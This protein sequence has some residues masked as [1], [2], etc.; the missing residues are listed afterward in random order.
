MDNLKEQIKGVINDLYGVDDVTVD[1]AS[2]PSEIE[3]DYSTNVAMRLARQAGKAPRQIAEEIIEKL[4]NSGF[5]FSIAGPGFIN[6]VVS[7]KSLQRQLD[8]VWSDDYGNNDSGKGRLAISEFPSTNIAKP[9]SV[10]HLRPGTQGWAAKKVLEANGWKVLTDNHLGDVGTPFG[11]WA[12]GFMRSG[13]DIEEVTVYDLGDIYIKM[14]ADLKAEEKVGKHE[15]ADEVQEW[16]KKLEAKDADAVKLSKHFGEISLK[17]T[18][19]VMDRLGISTDMEMGE[20]NFVELGKKMVEKYADEGIFERNE[21]GSV[22]CRLDDYGI[23][24][25]ML[26][27][28][29]NGTALYATTD[30]G[31]L[32]Y[33]DENIHPDKIVYAVGAEQKFYFEQLFAMAKKV[34][35]KFDNYH[36]VFGTIDQISPEGKREKMSSRKGVVLM[37]SL[38][39]DAEK[40]VRENFGADVTDE[41]I[42]KIAVGAI[43]FSDFVA[44]RNTGILYDPDKIFA[45]TGQSGPFC[46]YACVRM[47]RIM[48]KNADFKAVGF[49]DYDFAAEKE[50]LQKLLEFPEV[51]AE[52]CEDFRM[53]KI[54]GFAFELAQ[55][56]NRYYE[57]TPISSAADSERSARLWL[58]KRADFVLARALDLL[59]IE[60]PEKM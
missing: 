38:L 23:D 21:D 20:S 49:D 5:G 37:E 26:M 22:I 27:L 42:A 47:R 30:L 32:T 14:K 51:V 12:V 17:H 3:G 36:L 25:P 43:K 53:H 59:G 15:L 16:L 48:E 18:H 45:L 60:I 28:K 54:A 19:E 24:V 50:V 55:E 13:L 39:D 1:F 44:D 29:S 34:G 57:K 52:A 10:G 31:C 56:L 8:E 2:V 9:Y 58:I 7:G 4:G 33:R 11:I 35:I 40:R 6:V 41:D 46:Q